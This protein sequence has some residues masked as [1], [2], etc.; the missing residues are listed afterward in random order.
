MISVLVL[1]LDAPLM[2]FGGTAVDNYGVTDDHPGT[3]MLAGLLANALGYDH[4]ETART[5]RLQSRLR[6]A[7]RADRAG[8][9]FVDYQTVDLGQPSLLG[10]GWTTHGVPEDR[11]GA[12]SEGTHIRYRHYI[13]DAIYTVAL[14]L[15]PA[16][17][18]PT[19]PELAAALQRPARPLFIGRKPCLPA[20]PLFLYTEDSPDLEAAIRSAPLAARRADKGSLTLWLPAD[21]ATGDG[22]TRYVRDQRDWANQIHSGE[23]LVR[24]DELHPPAEAA[25]VR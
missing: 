10:M 18:A 5:Q 6:H 22:R 7:A 20:A 17:E 14:T 12:F 3:S 8:S 24:V 21:E 13:A 2:S 25:D 15:E 1:R 19:L 23:R 4:R 11:A 16:D 9:R